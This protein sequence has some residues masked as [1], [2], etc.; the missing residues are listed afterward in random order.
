MKKE[1]NLQAPRKQALNIPVVMGSFLLMLFNV[2]GTITWIN[3][4]TSGRF[5]EWWVFILITVCGLAALI[6]ASKFA[7]SI[8][9]WFF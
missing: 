6:F 9:V 5:V 4:Y 3:L 2:G 7:K 1:Q 8:R